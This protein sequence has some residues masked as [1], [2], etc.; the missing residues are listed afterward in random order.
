MC[1]NNYVIL[2]LLLNNKLMRLH[3]PLLL[4]VLTT[5]TGEEKKKLPV[6]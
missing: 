6:N 3:C 4:P 2:C 1:I 5:E